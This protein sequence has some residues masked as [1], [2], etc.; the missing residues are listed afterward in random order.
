MGTKQLTMN[1]KAKWAPLIRERDYEK[2]EKET[3]FYCEQRFIK[4]KKWQK[5]WDHLNN[6]ESDNRPENLPN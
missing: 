4:S 1:Q 3:C 5:V 6:N 2:G